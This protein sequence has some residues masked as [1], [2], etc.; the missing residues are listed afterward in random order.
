MGDQPTEVFAA[1]S[2]DINQATTGALFGSLSLASQRGIK[3]FHLLFQS[4]GG[5]IGDGIALYNFIRTLPFDLHM[6]NC[7]GVS[8]AAVLPY[9]AATRRIAS[10]HS[11]F[12]IHKSACL[13]QVSAQAA[14]LQVVAEALKGDDARVEAILKSHTKIPEDQWALHLHRDIFFDAEQAVN[15][16]IADVI[17]EFQVPRETMIYN[18]G[19][20]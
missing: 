3:T 6:Y 1:F 9:L 12:L 13:G 11:R 18:I 15:F 14:H 4:T 17:G 20:G 10:K 2:G 5:L 16:T 8:S 7:G 19:P